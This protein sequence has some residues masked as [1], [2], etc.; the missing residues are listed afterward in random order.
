M[1][2]NN[3]QFSDVTL[4]SLA[5][6]L[7]HKNRDAKYFNMFLS[8]QELNTRWDRIIF[9]DIEYM[10]IRNSL[11]E[12]TY[13]RIKRKQEYNKIYIDQQF[14]E[15]AILHLTDGTKIKK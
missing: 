15:P 6:Y 2:T 1:T 8:T 14:K 4:Y 13:Q 10:K 11:P 12:K 3:N 5:Y 9:R 7:A